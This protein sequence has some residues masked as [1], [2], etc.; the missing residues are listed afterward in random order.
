MGFPGGSLVKN[1]PANAGHTA[2]IPGSE[3]PSGEGNGDPLQDSCLEN[4]SNGGAWWA[5]VY[6]VAQSRTRLKQLSSS[7]S[8][9]TSLVAQLIKNLP[10]MQETPVQ[11]LGWEYALEKE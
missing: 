1:P 10:A 3:R 8:S 7:S 5:T 11:F 2:S 6:G 9:R 4:P